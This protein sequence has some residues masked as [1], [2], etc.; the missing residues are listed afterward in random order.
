MV[1]VN[2][3][4]SCGLVAFNS[5]DQPTSYNFDAQ[6]HSESEWAI[7]K[8]SVVVKLIVNEGI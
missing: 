8:S 3:I 2:W 5:L 7:R 1:N 6:F 4:I